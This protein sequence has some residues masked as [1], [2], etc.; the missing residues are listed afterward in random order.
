MNLSAI[1]EDHEVYEAYMS[2]LTLAR[3]LNGFDAAT[4]N[5]FFDF[6]GP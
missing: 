1:G 2:A 3:S 6:S 5:N 4:E